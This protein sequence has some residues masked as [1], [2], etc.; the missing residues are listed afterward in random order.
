MKRN[1]IFRS[2]LIGL[3]V[4][5]MGIL[6]AQPP[7]GINYQG[8]VRNSNGDVMANKSIDIRFT[9]LQDSTNNVYQEWQTVMTNAHGLFSAVIGQGNVGSGSFSD[10]DW[11]NHEEYLKVEI[12]TG[13]GY[14]GMGVSKL[15]SVPYALNAGNVAWDRADNGSISYADTLPSGN[16]DLSQ[17]AIYSNSSLTN[18]SQVLK[19]QA[20]GSSSDFQFMEMET[21]TYYFPPGSGLPIITSDT[22]ASIEGDGTANFRN[23]KPDTLGNTAVPDTGTVYQ[24]NVPMAWGY[25]NAFAGSPEIISDFGIKSISKTGTGDYTITLDHSWAGL[26]AITVTS[27]E[28]G[29]VENTAVAK[30]LKDS[31][32]FAVEVRDGSGNL[33]DSDF[34]VVVFG[35]IK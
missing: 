2:I 14:T 20:P 32:N 27:V 8:V 29:G 10:I 26:P 21:Q 33:T 30:I 25:I 17:V 24:D 13:S 12:D 18:N 9:V 11:D 23:L 15:Q 5:V 31:D 16:A 34:M 1:Y 22:K 7:N 4:L 6:N 19:L 35:R 28:S 3:S